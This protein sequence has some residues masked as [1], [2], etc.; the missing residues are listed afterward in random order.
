MFG[1]RK[2]P[3]IYGTD[4]DDTLIG[5]DGDDAMVGFAGNDR[6]NGG[7][8]SDT[9]YGSAGNDELLGGGG[10]DYLWGGDGDDILFGE[11]GDDS[12]SGGLGNDRLDGG[13]GNDVFL[14]RNDFTY[15]SDLS[16]GDQFIGGDGVDRIIFNGDFT[17]GTD[18]DIRSI[19][20]S[21]I[22][23]IVA[24]VPVSLTFAQLSGFS[25]L[26]GIFRV[27]GSGTL[28]LTDGRFTAGSLYLGGG[29]D[30][31][32]LAGTFSTDFTSLNGGAGN[33]QLTG[34]EAGDGLSGDDGDDVLAGRGGADYLAGGAGNDVLDG[35]TGNDQ[36]SGGSGA[37]T[38][39]IAAL[40]GSDIITDFASSEDKIDILAYGFASFGD[41][42]SRASQSGGNVLIQLG[43]AQQLTLWN[44]Q[45]SSLTAANFTGV[46]TSLT[47]TLAPVPP[48]WSVGTPGNDYLVEYVPIGPGPAAIDLGTGYDSVLLYASPAGGLTISNVET[49]IFN[50][51]WTVPGSWGPITVN[52][53]TTGFGGDFITLQTF[54]DSTLMGTGWPG[55]VSPFGYGLMRLVQSGD[56]TILQVDYRGTGV[57]TDFVTFTHTLASAFVA[58]NFFGNGWTLDVPP[59]GWT[60]SGSALDETIYG[61]AGADVLNGGGG[62]DLLIGGYGNDQLTGGA[63]SDIFRL[64]RMIEGVDPGS[65]PS[66]TDFN[67]AQDQ[68]DIREYGFRYYAEILSR[69]YQDGANVVIEFAPMERLTLNNVQLSSLSAANFVG[70]VAG[71]GVATYLPPPETIEP[72]LLVQ[73]TLNGPYTIPAGQTLFGY[74]GGGLVNVVGGNGQV[75]LTNNG[76]LWSSGYGNNYIAQQFGSVVNNGAMYAISDGYSGIFQYG[77]NQLTNTGIMAATAW[78]GDATALTLSHVEVTN[79]GTIS[80][81][82]GRG[83]SFAILC[84]SGIGYNE[85]IRNLPTGRIVV[86]APDAIAIYVNGNSISPEH[87]PI[88]NQGLIQADS[89]SDLASVGIFVGEASFRGFMSIVNSGTITA[90]IAILFTARPQYIEYSGA[91]L[92]TNESGGQINGDIILLEAGDTFT[93][94]GTFNGDFYGNGGDDRVDT[95]TGRINGYVDLGNGADQY[96]GSAFADDV[97]GGAGND[98]LAGNGGNDVLDGGTGADAMDGGAG[99]DIFVVDDLGDSI[100]DVSGIDLV[101]ASISYT[102]GS[103]IE[104]LTLIGTAALDGTGNNLANII[105]GNS[106]ANLLTGGGGDDWLFG[107]G[108]QDVLVGGAGADRFCFDLAPAMGVARISDFALGDTIQLDIAVF[109]T[110]TVGALGASAFVQGTAATASSNRIVYDSATGNIFYDADGTGSVSG[111]LFATVSIGTQLSSA[112]FV[113]YGS[114]PVS[115]LS[116]ATATLSPTQ[117]DLTLI[118]LALIDGTGNESDNT[119]VGNGAAN[120]LSGLG[121]SDV[122]LGAGG[123]DTLRGGFDDDQLSG[124]AGN[125]RLDG[126]PGNDL[127][128]GDAGTDTADYGSASAAV[129]VD[130]RITDRQDTIGSGFDTLATIENITGSAFNDTLIGNELDNILIGGTGMDLLSGGRGNDVI[131]GGTGID[132]VSYLGAWNGVTVSLAIAGWQAIDMFE[133]DSLVSIENVIGSDLSDRITGNAGDNILIGGAGADILEGGDGNDFLNGSDATHASLGTDTASY[134]GASSGVTVSLMTIAAQDTGGA[135]VDTLNSIEN[136]TGSEFADRLTGADDA[137]LLLGNGGNDILVGNGG[138][139]MLLGSA[140]ADTLFGGLGNDTLNGGTGADNLSGGAGNDSYEV[141]QAGDIVTEAVDDGYDT[142]WASATYV[143]PDNVENLGLI[144]TLGVIAASVIDGTGNGMNN[145]I[146]GNEAANLLSGLAGHDAIDGGWG[147]DVLDGG[148]GN[149]LLN[150]GYGDDILIGGIGDDQL[151]GGSGFDTASYAS[152]LAGVTV[153]LAIAGAQNTGAAG[154]DSLSEIEALRGSSFDDIL[155]SGAFADMLTGGGGNDQFRGSAASLNGDT[156]T[157]FAA[158][159]K[160]VFSD[161]TIAGFS[162]SLT[163]NTLTYTGG[164]L[165]LSSAIAG[166]LVASAAAGGGVQI[167]IQPIDAANDFNGDGRSDILWRNV[168]TGQV[169]DWLGQA[170]GGFVGNDANAFATVPT[171]WTIVGTGD[172][173]GDG[174]DDILWRNSN[175]QLSDWLGTANGGFTPNDA[176]ALTTVATIWSVVGTGDFNGD[177]RDDILWRNSNGQLSDWLGQANG[178]FVGNDAAA[179]T[180]VPTNWHVAGVGDFNGDGRDDIL[181]RND[182]GQLSDW[183]G[184]TNG[185]FTPN[186]ANAF[187]SAPT[188]WHIVGTG[189]FNGDGRDDI[190]WRSDA[191]QLSNWLGQANGGFV[192]NDANAFTTVPTSWTVVAV[193]DYNGDGRDDI[194]WRNSNGQLSDWLG[195]ANGGFTPNDGNASTNVP[196]NWHVQS[197]AFVL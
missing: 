72:N 161:A 10:V 63:G 192:G 137:N 19:A 24:E 100:A 83:T 96:L 75:Q 99:D 42:L 103:A 85:Y 47:V 108:G 145:V 147:D 80:A 197:E 112:S 54:A 55:N 56:N 38:Y 106:G 193:G 139:D 163:G 40:A 160:I 156:I 41:V 51:D 150:G 13:I 146:T 135:G 43:L 116:A 111:V 16:A 173:N 61:T 79:S 190:L 27:T 142:I 37:D 149:D 36:L 180:T 157:D 189:D 121:G 127:M 159:D 25:Q 186:D 2:M 5:T 182:A 165:T 187:A 90:D 45:L 77:V 8:G 93:N 151:I 91:A 7:L 178:G 94:R 104:D 53:F 34:G 169:S 97:F 118:G 162:I 119:L 114:P 92:I 122:L 144:G 44:V 71:G 113:A 74:F 133:S 23:Q 132:T 26:R 65:R 138:D 130:L 125:D 17:A 129:T 177:G 49:I 191:G 28:N 33:D 67:P 98:V 107:G 39:V 95:T 57:F 140:G 59:P 69:A 188:S 48:L 11:A 172:F 179:F 131:D 12:L 84:G 14:V 155:T 68:I 35:G 174:R 194:L 87:I 123:D 175:G 105:V 143:L 184:Q 183:L 154:V 117:I 110:L 148:T 152:A 18:F 109:T 64:T 158:G 30:I 196:T 32:S 29:N 81:R 4:N 195:N 128:I 168:T 62:N 78:T 88:N 60:S 134:A 70:V 50:H 164:A 1:V 185:G 176:N 181:W 141:D 46:T 136:L 21:G 170:N 9:L 20:I 31:V 166:R 22:E 101:Y 86:E 171:S 76:T 15:G 58:P 115:I 124:G 153:S 3:S 6:L 82:G 89:T 66:I 120:L 167:A 73:T 52:D 102:L 126:G